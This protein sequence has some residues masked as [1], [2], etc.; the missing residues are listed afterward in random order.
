MM[1]ENGI[2]VERSKKYKVTT[3]S[4]HAVNIA[5]NLLNR[6]FNA[7]RPRNGLEI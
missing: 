3:D 7:D 5:P 4:K 1:R 2:R 6:D